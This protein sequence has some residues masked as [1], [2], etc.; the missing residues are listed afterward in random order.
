MMKENK[1]SHITKGSVLD[2]LGLSGPVSSAIKIKSCLLDDIYMIIE[3][4][5]Y[6]PRDLSKIL[7]QPQPRVS[8]LLTG[9][10]SKVSIE[11]LLGYLDKLGGS[12]EI[13]VDRAM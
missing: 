10:I 1:P 13:R 8:E 12:A 11:K 4:K 6:D 2:D 9:K 7:D 5:E 3:E